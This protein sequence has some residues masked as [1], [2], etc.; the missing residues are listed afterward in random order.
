MRDKIGNK[1]TDKSLLCWHPSP[2]E[3]R[4]GL[5]V[6]AVNVTDGGL[7]L[8]DSRELTP[9]M[10]VIQIPIFVN[11]PEG[12]EA[13]LSEFLCVVNPQAEAAIEKMLEGRPKQ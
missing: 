11:A 12:K 1:I 4:T 9:P 5:M 10:L 8:G 13:T 3:L 6:Q 7:S 2:D